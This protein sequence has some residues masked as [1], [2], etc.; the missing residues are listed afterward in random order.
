MS[1]TDFKPYLPDRVI[2]LIFLFLVLTAFSPA[3]SP[4]F[5]T[6][7]HAGF[8]GYSDIG[9]CRVPGTAA[10]NPDSQV[11]SITG[12]GKNMWF[13]D[14]HFSFAWKKISGDF[15]MTAEFKLAGKGVNAHRKTGLMIRRS[16]D[17]NS[18]YADAVIH[19][20]GLAALQFR[21]GSGAETEEK[22]SPYPAPQ[23]LQLE[24][25]GNRIT[26]RTAAPGQPLVT[27]G[28][29]EI[30]LGEEVY[31]GLAICS[32]EE[33]ISEKAMVSNLRI[34]IPASPDIIPYQDYSG[35]R[36]EILDLET[37]LRK[38]VLDSEIPL[39]A[40]N[41][42][43]DGK[44]LIYNSQGRL[45]RFDLEKGES[46]PIDTGNAVRNNN[47][48]VISWSGHLLGI[49]HQLENSSIEGSVISIIPIEGGPP[50]LITDKAPSYLHGWSADDRFL[51]YTARRNKQYDIYRIPVTGGDEIQLTDQKTLDD[52]PEYSPDGQWIYFNSART[53]T[54]QIWRMRA[55]GSGQEQLTFDQWNDWFP[56]IS[57]DGKNVIFLSYPPEVEAESHPHYKHVMLR[58][59]APGGGTPRVEAWLYGGQGTINVPSWSPDSKRA[60]FVSCSF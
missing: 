25:S 28:S 49:S 48:H 10:Y 5:K 4:A 39:E 23:V 32:H 3:E 1:K 7:D 60:A 29:I 52:G 14:D 21:R 46:T 2:G 18:P 50:E 38:I 27:T 35:S 42:T 44:S 17:S 59:M 9:E 11:Y 41:W 43:R 19:G 45:Y 56:H 36:L 47:D 30:S 15:L 53:G 51:V 22:R 6:R 34:E 54:M 57:P 16:L 40:P 37:G 12:S 24:R 8:Q 20:D 33:G 55:D 31:A 13:K 58:T 26:M